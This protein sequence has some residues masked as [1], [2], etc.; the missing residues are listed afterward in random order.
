MRAA[1]FPK[2][3]TWRNLDVRSHICDYI[4]HTIS[5]MHFPHPPTHTYTPKAHMYCKYVYSI[6]SKK[7]DRGEQMVDSCV[8]CNNRYWLLV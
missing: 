1:M 4:K 6:N 2:V 5:D 8:T 7:L 3:Q